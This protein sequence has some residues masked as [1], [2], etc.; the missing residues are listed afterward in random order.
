M[1]KSYR[2]V[3]LVSE[4]DTGVYYTTKKPTKGPKTATKLR[5]RKYDKKLRKHCWFKEVRKLK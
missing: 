1:A 2:L 4:E 3:K 5:F